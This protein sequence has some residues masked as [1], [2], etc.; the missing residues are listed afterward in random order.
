[1]ALRSCVER[2][3]ARRTP[4]RLIH[5]LAIGLGG[6]VALAASSDLAIA[7]PA[8]EPNPAPAPGPGPIA[9]DFSTDL[10]AGGSS[11]VDVK[12]FSLGN[13]QLAGNYRADIYL[14]G[15]WLQRR[16]IRLAGNPPV[17]CIDIALLRSLGISATSLSPQ[18]ASLLEASTN[19]GPASNC[20]SLE[21]LTLNSRATFEPNDLRLDVTVPQASLARQPRGYVPPSAWDHGV[22]AA[23]LS[24]NINAN[25]TSGSYQSETVYA[26]L[27]AGFNVDRWRMRHAGSF[28]AASGQSSHY[29]SFSNFVMTDLPDWRATVSLGDVNTSGQL[30]RSAQVR[31]MSITSDERM[32]PDSQRGYA[33]IIRGVANSNARVEIRQNRNLVYSTTVPPGPFEINDLYPTGSGDLQVI[34]TEADGTQR[35]STQP[36]AALPQLLRA[37]NLY[38]SVHAGQLRGF[39]TKHDVV[40]ATAQYGVSND[41][42]VAGGIQ[43]ANRY[44]ALLVGAALNTPVG[45]V[46]ANVTGAS[47]QHPGQPRRNGWSLDTSWAKLIAATNTSF[48]LAAYRYSSSAFYSLDD[49]MRTQDL[50]VS[51]AGAVLSS[52]VRERASLSVYQ[53]LSSGLA[54][55]ISANTE[56]YWSQSNRQSSVQLGLY[57]QLGPAQ[58]SFNAVRN[59]NQ[60]TGAAQRIYTVGLTL[61]LGGPGTVRSNLSV[62]GTHDA[63][64]GDSQRLG[65]F[66]SAGERGELSY[67]LSATHGAGDRFLSASGGY[68]AKYAVLNAS[69]SSGRGSQQQS[70]GASGGLVVAD[71]HV[72]FAP[73]LGETMGL[74]RVEGGQGVRVAA[75]QASEVDRNGYTLLPYLSP[76]T[77]NQIELD[78]NK[79]PLSARFDANS[80]TVAP[81]AG[82]VVL[83]R[84]NRLP[85]YTLMLQA[86]RNDGSALPF[87]ASVYDDAENLVGSVAQAGR[88]EASTSR[89]DGTLRVTWGE[90]A[91]QSCTIRY[92]LPK[93]PPG[94]DDVIRTQVK[95][96]PIVASALEASSAPGSP[97]PEPAR[98]MLPR[99]EPKVAAPSLEERSQAKVTPQVVVVT[100]GQ[101]AAL[102]IGAEL[103]F[104]DAPERVSVVAQ[105]GRARIR[106]PD[107]H[108]APALLMARW[109]DTAGG[110]QACAVTNGAQATTSDSST[111]NCTYRA[112]PA[113]PNSLGRQG[114][115]P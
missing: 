115:T 33:P 91:A 41:L 52:R 77:A 88:I 27:N 97:L 70:L 55:N 5:A 20:M 102:P 34:V 64:G 66:G 99:S 73:Y 113:D 19:A 28:S 72:V 60:L 16:D 68:T 14:N 50:D 87:G 48:N 24:Y 29:S 26:G 9:Y 98:P 32:L 31:G 84:F 40:Q 80:T 93:P 15:N 11:R 83:L 46:Q 45:A 89:L 37:G 92:D 75:S 12:R 10:L 65:F 94:E 51:G 8:P 4:R 17:I 25:R 78:L 53:T 106:L 109:T 43:L 79:A 105:G 39:A 54:F 95:C 58:L 21:M 57:K 101:G 86:R 2:M 13:P 6:W 104:A 82:A 69:A 103:S 35:T 81:Y 74:L 1:M 3:A 110:T 22:T 63:T 85:G 38:Y 62:Y 111:V 112:V 56:N 47:L 96:L 71:G 18:G 44:S 42:S 61:P 107:S 7:A 23:M 76:Y 100:D 49:A 114:L 36:F 59:R 67:G 30:F 90:G 108:A